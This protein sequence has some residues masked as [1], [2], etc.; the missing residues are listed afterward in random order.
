MFKDIRTR[1]TTGCG[2]KRGKLYYLD[3]EP[4][5]SNK[6]LQAWTVDG[7]QGEK[8]K[9]DIRL[10]HRRLGQASFGYLKK[11]FPS[12]FAKVNVSSFQ[13]DVCDL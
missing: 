2:I 9:F 3:L 4:N 7:S 12:L 1:Q 5:S 11:L 6:L 13:C 8:E 10:W